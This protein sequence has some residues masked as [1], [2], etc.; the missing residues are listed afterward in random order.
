MDILGDRIA[1][2][3]PELVG[4]VKRIHVD[5]FR[6][7]FQS[8]VVHVMGMDIIGYGI[9]PLRQPVLR[10][11]CLID[12]KVMEIL[13]VIQKLGEQAVYHERRSFPGCRPDGTA[14]RFRSE[15]VPIPS[16]GLQGNGRW[17]HVHEMV[18]GA[19]HRSP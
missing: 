11:L 14:P 1:G 2:N 17:V 15:S 4:Q 19:F 7:L 10:I 12:V 8:Q 9:N 5:I 18:S 3:L 6:Q 16:A 13:Q